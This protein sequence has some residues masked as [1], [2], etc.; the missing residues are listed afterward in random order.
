MEVTVSEPY[1]VS[2]VLKRS[3]IAAM[4]DLWTSKAAR[5]K[6]LSLNKV[7]SKTP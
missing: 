4:A 7:F 5:D 2:R 3:T 6:F 1:D